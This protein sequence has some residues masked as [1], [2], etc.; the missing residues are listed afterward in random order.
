METPCHD[1]PLQGMYVVNLEVQH[2]S[3]MLPLYL[4]R[5]RPIRVSDLQEKIAKVSCIPLCMQRIYFEGQYLHRWPN[6]RLLDFGVVNGVRL[7]LAGTT[8]TRHDPKCTECLVW[9]DCK[10]C[11]QLLSFVVRLP[12][13]SMAE[14]TNLG[15]T[16]RRIHENSE[17]VSMQSVNREVKLVQYSLQME[18]NFV[19]MIGFLGLQ[20]MDFGDEPEPPQRESRGHEPL[21]LLFQTKRGDGIGVVGGGGIGVV[22]G[23]G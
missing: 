13:I 2:G 14:S 15:N 3:T 16:K 7:T 9:M 23:S 18:F 11:G 19:L 10:L 5:D 22:G 4:Q 6:A 12:V 17:L 21:E 1:Y 8:C 20:S